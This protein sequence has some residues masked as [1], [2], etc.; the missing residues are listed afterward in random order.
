M[1]TAAG[2]KQLVSGTQAALESLAKLGCAAVVLE[3]AA[4]ATGI[5]CDEVGAAAGATVD[6]GPET[7]SSW[8][9]CELC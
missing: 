1:L 3:V 9:D 5:W 4:V 6:V 8:L 7:L 2:T